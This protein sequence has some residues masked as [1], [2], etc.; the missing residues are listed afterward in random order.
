MGKTLVEKLAAARRVSVPLVAIETADPAATVRL[1]KNEAVLASVAEHPTALIGWDCVAGL[2]PLNQAGQAALA[3]AG[4]A[5]GSQDPIAMLLGLDKLP[6]GSVVLASNFH[7][8]IGDVAVMQAT[9]NLRDVLKGNFRMLVLLAPSW[10]LPGELASDVVVVDHPLPDAVAIGERVASVMKSAKLPGKVPEHAVDALR[11]LTAFQAEQQAA[12][13][14][15]KTGIDV[16]DLWDQKRKLVA[17]TPG[18]AIESSPAKFTDIG[19]VSEVKTFLKAILSGKRRPKAIVFIDEIEKALAGFGGDTS[20]VAQD[21]VGTLLSY[22]QDNRSTGCLF[23][24]HAGAAK[25][26]IAKAAGVE[27]GLPTVRLDL[28]ATKGSLVGQSEEQLRAALKVI[29]AVSDGSALWIATCNSIGVLPPELRR[30]FSLGTFFFDLPTAE[31]RA[32]IWKIYLA[33]FGL[34]GPLPN[35]DGWT[36]AEI[37]RC[38]DL[39]DR[40]G[41][42]VKVAAASVVPSAK[43][44]ADSIAKLRASASGK[45]LSASQPGVYVAALE[46]QKPIDAN[47]G[48]Q[49]VL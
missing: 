30:R 2:K 34:K 31:E 4:I 15:R 12:M 13:A 23:L 14:A 36:G 20:G 47:D 44:A 35:D 32:Q 17:Q 21:Q 24:G 41:V 26:V 1:W 27:C 37:E 46:G 5:D 3:D 39:A 19:G 6:A 16:D 9:W 28:G 38:C 7:R 10:Q 18:L 49:M 29:T 11:G 45:Y 25:S 8:F 22:M 43:S 33:K 42:P 40:M 48:R